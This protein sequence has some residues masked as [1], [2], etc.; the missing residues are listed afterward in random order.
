MRKAINKLSG[1]S[2][3]IVSLI[4][5]LLLISS[6]PLSAFAEIQSS[7]NNANR[8]VGSQMHANTQN[9]GQRFIVDDN[10]FI[11]YYVDRSTG[12][13]YILPSSLPLDETKEPSFGSLRIDG[14][15]YVF[16]GNYPNSEFVLP[17]VLNH[18]GTCQAVWRID[19]V[20]VT[21][22]INIIKNDLTE[23]SYAVYIRYEIESAYEGVE[24]DVDF[25]GRVL[26]DSIF[27][28]DDSLSIS[29]SDDAGTTIS[30][31]TTLTVMELPV[32]YE[33]NDNS[34]TPFRTYGL[35]NHESVTKPEK[36]TFAHFNNAVG[37]V[38]DYIA[39]GDVDFTSGNNKFGAADSAVLLYFKGV[40]TFEGG[41]KY[42]STIYGFEGIKLSQLNAF[43]QV[44]D[45]QTTMSSD[46]ELSMMYPEGI[47]SAGSE[48][49]LLVHPDGSLWV[50]GNNDYGQLGYGADDE[51]IERGYEPVYIMEGITKVS[52][53]DWHSLAIDSNKGLWTW[54]NNE[55]GQLGDGTTVN[56]NEPVK[57]MDDVI[58]ASA[59][60]GFTLAIDSNGNLWAWGRNSSG[61][62]GDGTTV[63][64]ALPVMIMTG[65]KSVSAG[66]SHALAIDNTDGLWA[67]GANDSGQ[68]GDNSTIDKQ[69][70][71]KVKDGICNVSA[72]GRHT[73]AVDIEGFL[74]VWGNND[75][76]QLGDNTT[77]RKL[78]P[79]NVVHWDTFTNIIAAGADH[80]LAMDEHRVYAW[81]RNDYGQLGDGTTANKNYPE[82]VL[83]SYTTKDVFAL[84]AGKSFSAGVTDAHYMDGNSLECWG[85]NS[86]GQL[87]T[88][89]EGEFMTVPNYAAHYIES[90][91][92]TIIPNDD[93]FGI[94]IFSG[95]TVG[96]GQHIQISVQ[97][98][99]EY[100]PDAGYKVINGVGIR[101][102]SKDVPFATAYGAASLYVEFILPYGDVYF[103]LDIV[104]GKVI[105]LTPDLQLNIDE[106][107][108]GV[109]FFDE[110][111]N[112]NYR[113][114]APGHEVTL[115]LTQYSNMIP[116]NVSIIGKNTSRSH[117]LNE[118]DRYDWG[119]YI[120]YV[121]TFIMPDEDVILF[122]DTR[123]DP[124]HKF[125]IFASAPAGRGTIMLSG[126]SMEQGFDGSQRMPAG[127]VVTIRIVGADHVHS[128]FHGIFVR[129]CFNG[130]DY[131]VTTIAHGEQ[132]S[133]VMPRADV[134]VVLDMRQKPIYPISSDSDGLEAQI[135]FSNIR[136]GAHAVGSLS[137]YEGD[138][139]AFSVTNRDVTK[140]FASVKLLD[141]S[142][143]AVLYTFNVD[144]AYADIFTG[145][146]SMPGGGVILLVEAI[147]APM[148]PV[149]VDDSLPTGTVINPL[150]GHVA[151]GSS[152]S[153]DFTTT[154]G[155]YLIYRPKLWVYDSNGDLLYAEPYQDDRSLTAGQVVSF[156]SEPI[157]RTG[158]VA[159]RIVL[160]VYGQSFEY[161][162]ELVSIRPN[163]E[164]A[165]LF[166]E[167]IA[168]GR[169]MLESDMG[170]IYI[171]V[172]PDSM[173]LAVATSF[174][175]DTIKLAIPVDMMPVDDDVTYYVRIND[176]VKSC[177]VT[178]TRELRKSPFGMLAV[179]S[180]SANRHSIIVGDSE[181]E[182][183]NLKGS[184]RII[185]SMIGSVKLNQDDDAWEFAEG[186]VLINNFVT[187]STAEDN[188][189]RVR[190][191]DGSNPQ[192]V[193]G[194]K[195][196]A[197]KGTM[198][199][200][201]NT[202]V[203]GEEI[204]INLRHG[205]RYIDTWAK[206]TSGNLINMGHE[207]I[208]VEYTNLDIGLAVVTAGFVLDLSDA[209]LLNNSIVFG[210]SAYLGIGATDDISFDFDKLDLDWLSK[211]VSVEVD[212]ALYA[213]NNAGGSYVF[214]G[215]ETRGNAKVPT[216]F[217]PGFPIKSEVELYINTF[218]N[219]FE[220][221]TKIKFP[222]LADTEFDA[223]VKLVMMSN[224]KFAVDAF[225]VIVGGEW[226]QVPVFPPFA[227]LRGIGAGASGLANHANPGAVNPFRVD[228]YAIME[229]VKLF[230]LNPIRMSIGA[231]EISFEAKAFMKIGPVTLDIMNRFEGGIYILNNGIRFNVSLDAVFVKGF[232]VINGG[233]H[234]N[235]EFVNGRFSFSGSLFVRIQVPQIQVL[236]IWIPP[237]FVITKWHIFPWKIQGY[238]VPARWEPIYIGPFTLLQ[239]NANISDTAV[240]A[241]F[242]VIGYGLR[243]DYV[244]GGTPSVR[245][246]T[247]DGIS[248][249][250]TVEY[251]IDDD[252]VYVGYV[253]YGSNLSI[254]AVPRVR[255]GN[256]LMSGNPQNL[257]DWIEI[258][259]VVYEGGIDPDDGEYYP[260][261]EYEDW[262]R[263]YITFPGDIGSHTDDYALMITASSND[264]RVTDPNGNPFVLRYAADVSGDG[265][266]E[267]DLNAAGVNAVVI[268]NGSDGP[269]QGGFGNRPGNTGR[270]DLNDDEPVTIMVRLPKQQGEWLVESTMAF[271]STIIRVAPLPEIDEAG[272]DG[273]NKISW[274]VNNLDTEENVY[275][276]EVR[277]STNDGADKANACPGVLIDEIILD[278][279]VINGS[280]S[281]VYTLDMDRIKDFDSWAY[282]PR[283]VLLAISRDEF[284]RNDD[285]ITDETT[286]MP[287][288]SRYAETPLMH[289]NVNEPA[290]V[291]LV[292]ISPDGGGTLRAQWTAADGKA[293]GYLLR[294]LGMNGNPVLME[295]EV[296]DENGI[297]SGTEL[298]P[299]SYDIPSELGE[300]GN[301]SIVLGGIE[302]GGTYQIELIPYANVDTVIDGE[303][304]TNT[305]RG[306]RTL[307]NMSELPLPNFP[308]IN[309]ALPGSG[310]YAD[311]VGNRVVYVNSDFSFGL[312]SNQPCR[313]TVVQNDEVIY[314]SAGF[315]ESALIRVSVSA[316]AS[317]SAIQITAVN[318]TG[319]ATFSNFITY[320]DDIAPVLFIIT[321]D[322]TGILSDQQGGYVIRG[323]SE[324]GAII[325]DDLGNTALA[326]E[327]GEFSLAGTLL[328]AAEDTLR[329][330]TASDAAGNHETADIIIKSIYGYLELLET[331]ETIPSGTVRL[332]VGE[333]FI[334]DA[335]GVL[336]DSRI[337][338]LPPNGVTYGIIS[339][340]GVISINDQTGRITAET[341][342]E[343]T[344]EVSLTYQGNTVR[345][346][347]VR[348][349]V[350]HDIPVTVLYGDA[351]E[352]NTVTLFDAIL[353]AQHVN[354]WPVRIHETAADVDGDG[355]VTLFDA[356][357]IAQYVNGWFDR[358]PVEMIGSAPQGFGS[359]GHARISES[360]AITG[361]SNAAAGEK[362]RI[363]LLSPDEA[364]K[365]GDIV[366]L[367]VRL[368]NNPGL[369][370]LAL[371]IGY[372]P[373]VFEPVSQSSITRV[374]DGLSN[375]LFTGHN[376]VSNRNGQLR[377]S[378]FGAEEDSSDGLLL[379]IQLRVKDTANTG[380]YE[381]SVSY[382]Q[383]NAIDQ[384]GGRIEL[385][386]INGSISVASADT[387][388]PGAGIGG[389][390]VF[391][392]TAV[393]IADKT[394]PLAEF[395]SFAD[396][397]YKR[398]LFQ[399]YRIGSDGNPVFGLE[400]P[401]TRIQALILTIRLLG[402][403]EEAL[404]FEGVNPFGDVPKYAEPYTAFAYANGITNGVRPNRFEPDRPITAQE[405]TAFLLRVLGYSDKAGMDFEYRD[406]L[407]KAVE[408]SLY[409]VETL[410]GLSEGVFLRDYAVTAMVHALLTNV[411]DDEDVMLIDTLVDSG[412]ITREQAD[413]FIAA[414]TVQIDRK[415][416]G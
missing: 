100:M 334:I 188:P 362:P 318:Q 305:F 113:A 182:L 225:R 29:L 392:P 398:G 331:I 234:A 276:L 328:F 32:F 306:I 375:L 99:L 309:T 414:V 30:N 181:S 326:D 176:V 223:M 224:G 220:F 323:Y 69:N 303:E 180:D 273:D 388:N 109:S 284:T 413:A 207:N 378:W 384:T 243:A 168:T 249:L 153:F 381:I 206:N 71:V 75:Y 115:H 123:D 294:V 110:Y 87:G 130:T 161:H 173:R 8:F 279:N 91:T 340:S 39:D 389:G 165:E 45:T 355:A 350:T 1:I 133:F 127:G 124:A 402:L 46:H 214:Q 349:I 393:E 82:E 387:D 288:H 230:E 401:L 315:E 28:L 89:I 339:G 155:R 198:S 143:N 291:A 70:P 280:A 152:V 357:L 345:S 313:F 307:S 231:S 20:F 49:G 185:L 391:I 84:S 359:H 405:F 74:W 379:E 35:I 147:D 268:S 235:L 209:I 211:W 296:F 255:G 178:V 412:A 240:S 395:V 409:N 54:G 145:E 21:Q 348:I 95:D 411:K 299:I 222:A 229:L 275:I 170:E 400:D 312:S 205:V 317:A 382:D 390:S 287:K 263:H 138:R 2:K 94:D 416:K 151:F 252:G 203:K 199:V 150:S 371:N 193:F 370:G 264:I 259:K 385:R 72:G 58:D 347:T 15:D 271:A 55:F 65:V 300:N 159:A 156:A 116:E 144:D 137:G 327:N 189:L 364:I 351:D 140:I 316:A 23:N 3:R 356:I 260:G 308:V 117:A 93:G 376:T 290:H 374:R 281:G 33:A 368:D 218:D 228:L 17:P 286:M 277:L 341:A 262:G 221:G 399:G 121:Y 283:L 169:N 5:V 330:I 407:K 63:D 247:S 112:S 410:G 22:I 373:D 125:N 85:T 78:T 244:Y 380:T 301:F 13:Y 372:D 194:V 261:F 10:G 79:A 366:S 148:I 227:T 96:I 88:A 34:T 184:D 344:L 272:F 119:N 139:I 167:I 83:F 103:E 86:S 166:T 129:N 219:V 25:E 128:D 172:S 406:T 24:L 107:Y 68:V 265:V 310:I 177:I 106:G 319:D 369:A 158:G 197:T 36:V 212:R 163:S 105:E 61:Q 270:N 51:A 43:S 126:D 352:D 386:C 19:N 204:E 285:S 257:E 98:Y 295:V 171:G 242:S 92:I 278:G 320:F 187:Y 192:E 9:Q 289:T 67:W 191:T 142:N 394:P 324:P 354:D 56:K 210:G 233:G 114:Y 132:Y 183:M 102:L 226:F 397:L 48:H 179:V 149:E 27:G 122:M 408:V 258:R 131:A 245:P 44:P 333:G 120:M 358:F 269:G 353:V 52:A 162:K 174:S 396:E 50:W 160:G 202:F 237:Y 208:V 200:P 76:G 250:E 363:T 403:E 135:E 256:S 108:F 73:L 80:S 367:Q 322:G 14:M 332:L 404:A 292:T 42:F 60:D 335:K 338:D 26:I 216:N 66:G 41:Q 186:N 254:A 146:F 337:I 298:T 62:L 361:T 7:I 377:V 157:R 343:A 415:P 241:F 232:D 274:S 134:D 314:K 304:F 164:R 365:P 37:T 196:D 12:G 4:L 267:D 53:G 104:D 342:G 47:V 329:S 238:W 282:Y 383:A 253:S 336:T 175:I 40:D 90:A 16:G 239:M 31:E 325:T 321:D 293:D 215:F 38:Y 64:K 297:V 154:D 6:L 101:S 11:K 18:G 195:I 59:G 118:I 311:G 81:G 136:S 217:I 77:E 97:Q 266:T 248:T 213:P 141:A 201:G 360:Y 246:Q 111:A 302:P 346:H 251:L 190:Q 57:I 236:S